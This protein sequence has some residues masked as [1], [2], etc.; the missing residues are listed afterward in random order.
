MAVVGVLQ[1]Q[2]STSWKI[3]GNSLPT[4]SVDTY[5]LGTTNSYPL[6]FRTNNSDRMYISTSGNVGV[7]TTLP[8]QMLHVVGGNIL[9][10][11]TSTSRA[12]GSTN[13]SLFFGSIINPTNQF[14]E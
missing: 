14:G 9:V 4:I 13:G 10:S 3:T 7:G 2:S 5:F 8:T 1:A 12:P 6:R 11:K